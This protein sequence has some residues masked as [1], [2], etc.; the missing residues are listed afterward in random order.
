MAAKVR[1]AHAA[2]TLLY[3]RI[4]AICEDSSSAEY[5]RLSRELYRLATGDG[6]EVAGRTLE[7]SKAI[8]IGIK[9]AELVHFLRLQRVPIL[10]LKRAWQS[11]LSW[12]DTPKPWLK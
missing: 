1:A 12:T 5:T 6:F 11:L 8:D 9:S 2:T 7:P 10:S 4:K 3:D